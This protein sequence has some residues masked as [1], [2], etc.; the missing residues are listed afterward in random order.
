MGDIMRKVRQ[1][2]IKSDYIY[3]GMAFIPFLNLGRK[4]GILSTSVAKIFKKKIHVNWGKP[5][6]KITEI[7]K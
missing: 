5:K 1:I 3:L 2:N 7:R 6:V 4:K